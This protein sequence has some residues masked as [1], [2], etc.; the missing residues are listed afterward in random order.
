MVKVNAAGDA[1]EFANDESGTDGL[2]SVSTSDPLRGDGTTGDPVTVINGGIRGTH[3]SSTANIAGD[4][5]ADNAITEEKIRDNE[6]ARAKLAGSVR[7]ELDGI[8]DNFIDLGD[9]PSAIGTSGQVVKVN[10]A[11]TAWSLPTMRPEL[12]A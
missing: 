6:V 10:S 2:T 5:L 12:G 4:S 9:T 8:P 1:L 7:T 3:I 11:G